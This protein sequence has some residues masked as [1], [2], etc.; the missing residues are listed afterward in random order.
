MSI[1]SLGGKADQL[2]QGFAF[3][4]VSWEMLRLSRGSDGTEE[5]LSSNSSHLVLYYRCDVV[6]EI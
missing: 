3:V 2:S 1:F 5:T 6:T 4:L